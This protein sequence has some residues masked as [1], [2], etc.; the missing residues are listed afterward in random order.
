[1]KQHS[2]T[3]TQVPNMPKTLP[4]QRKWLETQSKF[5]ENYTVFPSMQKRFDELVAQN[6]LHDARALACEYGIWDGQ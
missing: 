2:N 3:K 4:A 6:R 5:L 1:M